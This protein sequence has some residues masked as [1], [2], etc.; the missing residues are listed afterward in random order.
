M[1]RGSATKETWCSPKSI[2]VSIFIFASSAGCNHNNPHGP[3]NTDESNESLHSDERAGKLRSL[4]EIKVIFWHGKASE[5]LVPVEG[6]QPLEAIEKI[7]GK[8]LKGR[9]VSHHSK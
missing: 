5:D 4:G 3:D 8:T 2:S 1:K 9:A 6:S 7:P